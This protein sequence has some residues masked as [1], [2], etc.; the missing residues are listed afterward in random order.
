MLDRTKMDAPPSGEL[1]LTDAEIE[2]FSRAV[3]AGHGLRRTFDMWLDIGK[4]I[5]V[6]QRRADAGGGGKKTRG[7][8]R[9]AILEKNGIGWVNGQSSEIVRLGQ[10]MRQLP[11]VEKWRATLTEYERTRR[12]TQSAASLPIRWRPAPPW[13][14]SPRTSCSVAA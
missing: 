9:M 10:V 6:A 1:V 3:A 4:A 8:R 2:I 14:A 7:I 11:A 12:P 13:R 5:Q